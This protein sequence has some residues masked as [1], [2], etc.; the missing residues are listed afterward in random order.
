ML[1]GSAISRLGGSL[2]EPLGRG[3]QA[4]LP[5]E[6]GGACPVGLRV[7]ELGDLRLVLEPRDAQIVAQ[8]VRL[9]R[10]AAA[11][12]RGVERAVLLEH[13]GRAPRPDPLGAW[14]LVGGIAA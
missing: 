6:R 8:G 5:E 13:P 1:I 7:R 9:V 4:P 10:K 2:A 3:V 12:E 14:N 11:L